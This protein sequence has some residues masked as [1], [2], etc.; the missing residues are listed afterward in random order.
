[1]AERRLIKE[2][3]QYKRN[4]PSSA[5]HQIKSLAPVS[6]ENLFEWSAVISKPTKV[7]NPY[8]YD[9]Q[10][11]LDIKVPIEYPIAPP[12]IKFISPI[13]HPNINITTGEICLDILKKDSWSP[14][15]NLQNL[16]VAI[17]MLL[18]NP[19]P[20]SPLNIDSAT[21]YRHDKVAFE[22]LVQ[23]YIWKFDTFYVVDNNLSSSMLRDPSGSKSFEIEEELQ[24]KSINNDVV[25]AVHE[26]KLEAEAIAQEIADE[27]GTDIRTS[28][29]IEKSEIVVPILEPVTSIP[30][31]ASTPELVTSTPEIIKPSSKLP[32]S[33]SYNDLTTAD[34]TS[35]SSR[36]KFKIKL[37]P[38]HKRKS[39]VKSS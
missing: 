21:L 10:W 8:Y 37:K 25:D 22:S 29:K 34:S 30:E 18:D 13:C 9:G 16:L 17:L 2:L 11:T 27:I 26:I 20:D 12:T 1:M 4:P 14:A 3:N 35:G 24:L 38:T 39:K 33:A 6:D 7:D 15:W 5:N 19:E 28:P 23:Y 31:V 32:T 36:S